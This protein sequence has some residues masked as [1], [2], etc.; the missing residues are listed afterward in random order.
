MI[1]SETKEAASEA[2][3]KWCAEH[4]CSLEYIDSNLE[5][6]SDHDDSRIVFYAK[7]SPANME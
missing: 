7:V 1:I 4:N 6:S 3:K 5:Q 2:A